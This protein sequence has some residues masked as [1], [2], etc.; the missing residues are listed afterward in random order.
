MRR[1]THARFLGVRQAQP[2][3]QPAR[4]VGCKHG[5]GAKT[6]H[7]I[8]CETARRLEDVVVCVLATAETDEN[9]LHRKLNVMAIDVQV[10]RSKEGPEPIVAQLRDAYWSTAGGLSALVFDRAM[11]DCDFNY[12]AE[13]VDSMPSLRS[14]I[15]DVAVFVFNELH[16]SEYSPLVAQERSKIRSRVPSL[17]TI[18]EEV[19]ATDRD[20]WREKAAYFAAI[21]LEFKDRTTQ[22]ESSSGYRS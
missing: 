11:A 7:G 20:V 17:G 22:A 14:R 5:Q 8:G 19:F 12:I 10:R 9:T 16:I 4:I 15:G 13:H 6:Q 2:V 1:R 21:V 3:A 18:S